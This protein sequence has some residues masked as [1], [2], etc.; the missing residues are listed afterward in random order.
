VTLR[1]RKGG[2]RESTRPRIRSTTNGTPGGTQLVRDINPGSGGSYPADLTN[3]NGTLF[4]SATNGVHGVELWKSDGTEAGTVLVKDI[5]PGSA[6]S[7]PSNLTN[8]NGMLFFSATNG[9]SRKADL[10]EVR[11][12]GGT[13]FVLRGW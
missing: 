10:V 11:L 8:V 3:V 9:V 13:R 1:V 5:D 7:S 2:V 12:R 6:G 4:F